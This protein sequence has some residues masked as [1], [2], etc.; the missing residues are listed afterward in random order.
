[1]TKQIK[2]KTLAHAIDR[3]L[4]RKAVVLSVML[5]ATVLF[6]VGGHAISSGARKEASKGTFSEAPAAKTANASITLA[7]TNSVQQGR[8]EEVRLSLSTSGFDPAEATRPAGPVAIMVEN[9]NISGEYTLQLKAENGTV[10]KEVTVQK[11]STGWADVLQAGSYTL[12]EAAHPQWV[13][14]IIIQ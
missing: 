1:M 2:S 11:G 5:I 4:S 10:V 8:P 14:H 7:S 13:C 3:K 6:T 12:T 9:V